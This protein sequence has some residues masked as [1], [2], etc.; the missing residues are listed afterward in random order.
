MKMAAEK[1]L[2][3][4]LKEGAELDLSN[5]SHL[6]MYVQQVLTRGTISDVQLLLKKISREGFADSFRRVK[7]F[8]PR[9]VRK[10]WEEWLGDTDRPSAKDP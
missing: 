9:L 3:W 4:Y 10:F 8:L 1:K 2:F 7:P 5:R 6:D